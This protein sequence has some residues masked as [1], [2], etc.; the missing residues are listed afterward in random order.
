MTFG[1]RIRN[2]QRV[3]QGLGVLYCPDA[4]NSVTAYAGRDLLITGFEQFPVYA[5]QV[6]LLLVHTKARVE[7]LH[8]VWIAMAFSAEIRNFSW[9]R[10]GHKALALIHSAGG[11]VLGRVSAMA[12]RT[13]QAP[14]KVYIV[15]GAANRF[16]Q[17]AFHLRVAFDT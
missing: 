3:D 10:S 16:Q 5:C 1:A 2:A 15:L 4:V 17:L 7:F 11:V 9:A 8:E 6:L 14:A 13:G 12:A